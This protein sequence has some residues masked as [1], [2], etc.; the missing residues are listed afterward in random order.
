MHIGMD[1]N[2][3]AN[4]PICAPFRG[5]VHSFK[6]NAQPFDYGPAIILQVFFS[7]PQDLSPHQGDA[8]N[9]CQ[10]IS[11]DVNKC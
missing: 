1:L 9:W 10:L 8:V 7:S 2:T 4:H 6:D 3:T 11:T 5:T